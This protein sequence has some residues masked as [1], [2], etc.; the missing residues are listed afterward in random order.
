MNY[1]SK[2]SFIFNWIHILIYRV[3][4]AQ[5]LSRLKEN[6][7]KIL[8]SQKRGGGGVK[9]GTNID[10]SLLL[11]QSPMFLRYNKRA[12][13]VLFCKNV[14]SVQKPKKVWSFFMW[15]ALPKTQRCVQT[16]ILRKLPIS[17]VSLI[18][19]NHN[20]WEKNKSIAIKGPSQNQY[21]LDLRLS[22]IVK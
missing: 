15:N 4:L 19:F 2:P 16:W 6:H 3:G 22:I 18:Y 10:L 20:R 1:M 7:L 17:I 21:Y 14:S 5:F 12:T 9:R 8:Y 13:P 11:R